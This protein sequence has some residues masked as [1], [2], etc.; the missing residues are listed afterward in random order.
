[1]ADLTRFIP[2]RLRHL[3]AAPT[4]SVGGGTSPIRLGDRIARVAEPIA[5]ACD[6]I[7]G[8]SLSTCGEC[9]SAKDALNRGGRRSDEPGRRVV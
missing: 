9:Q 5:A 6:R 8:T 1:M 2:E 3:L 7:L 4:T